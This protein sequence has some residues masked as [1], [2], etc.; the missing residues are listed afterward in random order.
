VTA[1]YT[2]KQIVAILKLIL[3]RFIRQFGTGL[4]VWVGSAITV[5]I[6]LYLGM[7]A[8]VY[9]ECAVFGR[10]TYFSRLPA[11]GWGTLFCYSTSK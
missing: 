10:V 1:Q 6:V 5:L 4:F 11:T 7:I 8:A 2:F 9:V 3:Q